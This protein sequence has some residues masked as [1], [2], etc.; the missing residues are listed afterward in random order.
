M[1]EGVD[2]RKDGGAVEGSSIVKGG[3]DVDCRLVHVRDAKVDLPHGGWVGGWY[4]S[5]SGL[6][7]FCLFCF[8]LNIRVSQRLFDDNDRKVGCEDYSPKSKLIDR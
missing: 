8:T 1:V 7:P 4:Q 5:Q 6:F 3:G 2:Q